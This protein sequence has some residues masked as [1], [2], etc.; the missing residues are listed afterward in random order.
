M[1][2]WRCS[3]CGYVHKGDEPPDKCP[4][5][6][7]DKSAFELIGEEA[8]PVAAK[9]VEKPSETLVE[10][11]RRCTVCGYI[12]TGE[13]PPDM[14][15]V[16]GSDKSAFEEVVEAPAP[17][18][19][20]SQ[21]GNVSAPTAAPSGVDEKT[22]PDQAQPALFERLWQGV[23]DQVMKHHIHPVSVHIPNG[24]LPISVLFI[25]LAM[26][27][28]NSALH[29]A[30]MYNMVLVVLTIPLVLAT[31]YIEWKNKYSGALTNRFKLKITAALVV[32]VSAIIIVLWWLANP[33]IL[34]SSP[35]AKFAFV[36]LNFIMLS[37]AVV[38]GLIGGKLVFRD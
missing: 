30:A 10:K 16:C 5:C 7:A 36:L 28:G 34:Q 26:V 35:G 15:P 33:D 32:S 4:V 29:T 11:K 31:G 9:E 23:V 14:C 12:H 6:G 20:P 25:V 17:A 27:T 13:E 18:G 8:E 2:K 1:K 21:A 3:V 38:A 24:V 22:E 37:A 19:K